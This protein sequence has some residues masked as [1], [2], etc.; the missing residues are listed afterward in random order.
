M[1]RHKIYED[2]QLVTL[3]AE[4]ATSK[5]QQNSDRRAIV[6][7]IIDRGGSARFSDINAH[8]G[9]DIRP[10]VMALIKLKWLRAA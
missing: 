4:E 2:D 10:Q 7:Y 6:N 9:Y 5:L 8:F 3:C 1:G